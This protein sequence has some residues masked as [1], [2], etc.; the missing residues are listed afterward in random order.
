M[1]LLNV[2]FKNRIFIRLFKITYLFFVGKTT[3]VTADA[4]VTVGFYK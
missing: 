3:C 4:A 1:K 2:L